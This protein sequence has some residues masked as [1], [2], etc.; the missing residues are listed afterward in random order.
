MDRKRQKEDRSTDPSRDKD[1]GRLWRLY[2][3]TLILCSPGFLRPAGATCFIWAQG[4][5]NGFAGL[6]LQSVARVAARLGWPGALGDLQINWWIIIFQD[7]NYHFRAMPSFQTN[8]FW[9]SLKAVTN[10]VRK[11]KVPSK[12]GLWMW[13]KK[14]EVEAKLRILEKEAKEEWKWY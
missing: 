5:G 2:Q 9:G 7:K 6:A 11:D 8:P 10:W 4:A 13:V 14:C 1:I 12:T 3:V